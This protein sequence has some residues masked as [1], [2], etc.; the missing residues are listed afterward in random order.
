ANLTENITLI[1]ADS[2]KDDILCTLWNEGRNNRC[3]DKKP[4][5]C[6]LRHCHNKTELDARCSQKTKG[7][8]TIYLFHFWCFLAHL[9]NK[10]ECTNFGTVIKTAERIWNALNPASPIHGKQESAT[11]T[12]ETNTTII[13]LVLSVFI[14]IILGISCFLQ[15]RRHKTQL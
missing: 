8:D 15:R 10:T 2:H 13:F 7:N 6:V 5:S 11:E 1:S 14:N 3:T 4:F 12:W 9:S